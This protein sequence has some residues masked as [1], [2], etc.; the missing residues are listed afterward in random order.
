MDM[1]LLSPNEL[2]E[3][4]LP[5]M[6]KR[7]EKIRLGYVPSPNEIEAIKRQRRMVSNRIYARES[8]KRKKEELDLLESENEQLRLRIKRLEEENNRLRLTSDPFESLFFLWSPFF[9]FPSSLFP[10]TPH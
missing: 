2:R 7:I 8:R 9:L 3:I 4:T 10:S 5:E 1:I 6:D